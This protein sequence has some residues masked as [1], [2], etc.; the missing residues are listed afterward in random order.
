MRVWVWRNSQKVYVRLAWYITH[1]AGLDYFMAA[2]RN[3]RY[4]V[5]SEAELHW[6]E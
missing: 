4:I 2:T 3:K 5:V 1:H 6:E